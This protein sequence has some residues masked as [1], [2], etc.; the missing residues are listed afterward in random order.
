[1]RLPEKESTWQLVISLGVGLAGVVLLIIAE[2]KHRQ[3][4]Q[5]L[6]EVKAIE[7]KEVCK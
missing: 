1:M 5:M 2:V 6:K 7:K 3:T 4:L